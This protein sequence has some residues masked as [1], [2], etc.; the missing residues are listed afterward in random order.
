MS[1]Q[2]HMF[3]TFVLVFARPL[4]SRGDETNAAITQSV[5][6]DL[7][8]TNVKEVYLLAFS[9]EVDNRG[10]AAGVYVY[11]ESALLAI[12]L[13]NNKWRLVHVYRHPKGRD[14]REHRWLIMTII[15]APCTGS[16]DYDN[17][18]TE[19][20][21]DKFLDDSWWRFRPDRGFHFVRSEIFYDNWKKALE[22]K[23]RY[24]FQNRRPN[25]A[26]EPTPTAP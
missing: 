14:E 8:Y 24:K 13:T 12:K 2:L 18:P 20:D 5:I 17:K 26:L 15:D 11:C 21:V 16:K 23:P 4:E 25:T 19:A 7:S 3:R 1:T 6:G 10:P 22:Y 9:G